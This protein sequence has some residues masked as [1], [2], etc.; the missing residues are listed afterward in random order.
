MSEQKQNEQEVL[1]TEELEAVAGGSPLAA[2]LPTI[3][4]G[5]IIFDPCPPFPGIDVE[6]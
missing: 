1:S 3:C 4:P 5:P 6:L 2:I